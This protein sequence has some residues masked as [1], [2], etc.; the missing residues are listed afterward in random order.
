MDKFE[1]YIQGTLTDEERKAYEEEMTS[2]EKKEA[3]FEIGMRSA[4]EEKS[5]D[6]LRE[7]ISSF[8]GK[9]ATSQIKPAYLAIAATIA[10]VA[11]FTFLLRPES[12]SLFDQYYESYPNYEFTA[13]RGD[14]TSNLKEKAY[15]AY[16]LKDYDLAASTFTELLKENAEDQPAQFFRGLCFLETGN[17]QD[18][19][20]DLRKVAESEN[21]YQEAAIWYSALIQT[22]LK[23]TVEA[24]ELLD[25]LSDS[26]EFGERA[27]ALSKEL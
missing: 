13:L 9:K 5:R 7:K 16:D 14:E 8:E 18:G 4:V 26:Q 25:L 23:N 2:E 1:K 6:E 17:Y 10:L 11:T 22:R 20:S 19:L 21:D 15:S 3:A 12:G 27:K 24:R